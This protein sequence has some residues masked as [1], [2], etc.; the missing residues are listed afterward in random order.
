[1]FSKQ[2]NGVKNVS[3][4][5]TKSPEYCTNSCYFSFI[6]AYISLIISKKSIEKDALKR[7][8]QAYFTNITQ[9]YILFGSLRKFTNIIHNKAVAKY[10]TLEE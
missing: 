2:K 1:M 8:F 3:S 10:N 6:K 5:N 9:N 7:I 4:R